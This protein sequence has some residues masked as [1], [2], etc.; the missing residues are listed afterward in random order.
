VSVSPI[1]EPRAKALASLSTSLGPNL[2]F[3]LTL[4]EAFPVV[5]FRHIPLHNTL[6]VQYPTPKT[7]SKGGIVVVEET[8]TIIQANQQIVKVVA[9]GPVAFKNRET[10]EQWPEGA[11]CKE[12]DFVRVGKYTP[13]KWEIKLGANGDEGV[14]IFGLIEDLNIR[15]KVTGDPLT[16]MAYI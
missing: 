9:V 4:E 10:L 2:L 1:K 14:A 7:V 6:I 13:D 16:I 11:W 5:D 8:R 3:D 15:A 12:G